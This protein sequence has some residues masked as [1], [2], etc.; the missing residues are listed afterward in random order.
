M[1]EVNNF[2]GSFTQIPNSFL[3]DKDLSSEARFLGIYI[4]SLP[5]SWDVCWEQ[6]AYEIGWSYSKIRKIA[7]ELVQAKILQKTELRDEKG[8]FCGKSQTI[9]TYKEPKIS[10]D[11]I[12]TDS[13]VENSKNEQAKPMQEPV[14]SDSIQVLQNPH[15]DF[16]QHKNKDLKEQRDSISRTRVCTREEN[17]SQNVNLSDSSEILKSETNQNTQESYMIFGRTDLKLNLWQI[18]K[19]GEQ[20]LKKSQKVALNPQDL[21]EAGLKAWQKFV[22]HRQNIRQFS[23]ESRKRAARKFEEFYQMGIDLDEAVEIAI[24]RGWFCFWDK[25][26]NLITG[27]K[28]KTETQNTQ[29][30][31]YIQ[32]RKPKL[33]WRAVLAKQEALDKNLA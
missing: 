32:T 13:S 18:F 25:Q 15:V 4:A 30:P 2:L 22:K 29:K 31:S 5:K 1:I 16:V 27:Q 12:E 7:K 20:S 28:T 26:G 8:L 3:R 17:L 6:V 33:D 11:F 23:S 10:E 9:I 24:S 19:S 21:N 14:L